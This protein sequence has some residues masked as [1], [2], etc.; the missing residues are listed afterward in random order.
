MVIVLI[1]N[2][3]SRNR[4]HHLRLPLEPAGFDIRLLRNAIN[5]DTSDYCDILH[6]T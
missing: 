2:M 3:R 5:I 6:Q 1:S 4:H